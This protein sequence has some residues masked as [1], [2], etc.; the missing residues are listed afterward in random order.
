[1]K[2]K[3]ELSDS[4]YAYVEDFVQGMYED[5]DGIKIEVIDDDTVEVKVTK[6]ADES[7]D[8]DIYPFVDFICYDMDKG[9]KL[10]TDIDADY[11]EDVASSYFE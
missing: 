3:E 8:E 2:N 10:H 4:I 7:N 1:M 9:G 11:V 5:T 6:D